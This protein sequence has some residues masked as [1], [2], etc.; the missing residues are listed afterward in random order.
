MMWAGGKGK[1]EIR[2]AIVTFGE[3]GNDSPINAAISVEGTSGISDENRVNF[4][5]REV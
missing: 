1:G 4:D 5:E 2:N 3:V